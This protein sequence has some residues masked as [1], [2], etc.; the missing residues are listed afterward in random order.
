MSGFDQQT[1]LASPTGATLNLLHTRPKDSAR[2]IVQINHGLA[3]HASRYARFANYLSGRGFA[4]YVHDH[5][6]HGETKAPDAPIGIFAKAPAGRAYEKVIADTLAVN[7]HA[8]ASYP[9]MPVITFGHSMGGLIAMNF[10]LSHPDRQSALALWN[11]NFKMGAEGRLAQAVL[12]GERMTLGS[13]VPSRLLPK[14]TFDAWGKSI[15]NAET[16]FDWLS[17]DRDQVAAYVADPLCGWDASV[18]LWQDVFAMAFRGGNGAALS[19]LPRSLPIH[20]VGGGQDPATNK[21][22]AVAWM[23]GHLRGNGFEN[24]TD[25]IYEGLRHETLNESAPPGA[26][27]AMEDFTAW[28]DA[29]LQSG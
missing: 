23:S 3:E 15:K 25:R 6:G 2:A 16:G 19:A 22:K 11:A 5:R 29:A 18:S 1:T 26:L 21:G 24:V 4:V 9:D 10:A 28:A 12:A 14:L 17:H 27:G 8:R 13:D 20:L 7:D